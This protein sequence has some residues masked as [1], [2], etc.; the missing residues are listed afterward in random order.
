M[1]A[2]VR[3]NPPAERLY[4]I[5]WR[6]FAVMMIAWFMSMLDMS[7]MNTALPELQHDFETDLPN[8]SWVVNV[9]S[10]VFAVL[11]IA[12]GRLA[13][14]FGRKKMFIGGLVVFTVGSAL[15][16]V[17][18]DIGW[19][20]GFRALQAIGAGMLAPL[21]F[22]MTALVF[23][24]RERGKGLAMI[25]V[26][27]LVANGLGPV[28]GG[29]LI[30]IA[31]WHWIFVINLPLGVIGV[32]LAWRW[33][34]ETYDLSA[35]RH[36][37][38]QGM[39]LLGASVSLFTYG[40]IEANVRGWDDAAILFFI[41]ISIVLGIGFVVWQKR[42][43]NPM[44]PPALLANKQFLSAN[45][46]M[47]ILG[48]GAVGGIFLLAQVFVNLWGFSQLEAGL[49]LLPI[50]VC[51]GLVWPLVA[52]AADNAPA[53]RL[54]VP[55]LGS[56]ALGLLWFSFMPSTYEGVGDY[57]FVLPG[58]I[59]IGMGIGV[60]FPTL[61]VGAMN[62]AMG[63][64]LGV[65]SGVV[66]TSR[67][68][69]SALG[70]AL[71]ITVFTTTAGWHYDGKK[72]HIEDTSYVWAVPNGISHGVIHH[73]IAEF[74][75]AVERKET[76]PVGFDRWLRREAA[77]IARD[78]FGWAFRLSALLLLFMIP[79]VRKLTLTPAEARA[80]AMAA[81]QRAAAA[82]PPSPPPAPVPVGGQPA[83]A[84]AG[85]VAVPN[86]GGVEGRIA[87]LEDAL[88]GLRAEVADGRR[89]GRS[90]GEERPQ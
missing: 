56:L 54:A 52:R 34:P 75:G 9:Y 63:P 42:A 86:G 59:L 39:V 55:A 7:I 30:E 61:N 66:N 6:V 57:L 2:K 16:A 21:G 8:A 37:D 48:A 60:G 82:A 18:W 53:Y 68:L 17:A 27:A 4:A 88:R 20:I 28:I 49:S 70:I 87:E 50:G 13:D 69:G 15:C 89:G 51:G 65:A 72:D 90:G 44:I 38:W 80:N 19:L 71:L 3:Q 81:A 26:V 36:I 45:L 12:T 41:Q 1:S 76:A 77:G 74:A 58:L 29:G 79:V 64:N 47:V 78:G 85:A 33:W 14:Q 23:P 10:I 25:A 62:A 24:P 43:R 32:V 46:A 73:D 40:L 84:A 67:Q 22:A 5:K 35:S 83:E 11:L 31:S